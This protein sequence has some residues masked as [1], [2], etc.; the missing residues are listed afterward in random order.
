MRERLAE[1]ERKKGK[2]ITKEYR[3]G[4]QRK[5]GVCVNT[6]KKSAALIWPIQN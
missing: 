2:G 5:L 4:E 3:K 1:K 6:R